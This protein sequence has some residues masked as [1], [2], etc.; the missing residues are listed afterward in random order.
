M[1]SCIPE[2]GSVRKRRLFIVDSNAFP[3][4]KA[5]EPATLC[6]YTMLQYNVESLSVR[7]SSKS[8]CLYLF[9]LRWSASS[10]REKQQEHPQIWWL[11][12]HQNSPVYWSTWDGQDSVFIGWHVCVC[13]YV[14]MYVRTYVCMYVCMYICIYIYYIYIYN[15]WHHGSTA[16]I[17]GWPT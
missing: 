17:Q 15:L 14:C 10:F 9:P 4:T 7:W 5:I 2:R 13:M 11:I 12:N 1:R 16:P 6:N 8:I 3:Q